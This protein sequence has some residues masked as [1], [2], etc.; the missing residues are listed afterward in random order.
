MRLYAEIG[1]SWQMIGKRMGN[2]SPPDIKNHFKSLQ[3]QT[4]TAWKST[5]SLWFP[6]GVAQIQTTAS[7][8]LEEGIAGNSDR[9]P[10]ISRGTPKTPMEFSIRGILA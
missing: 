9:S 6:M 8:K 5:H 10:S 2:R 3:K 4:T 1:P 7:G